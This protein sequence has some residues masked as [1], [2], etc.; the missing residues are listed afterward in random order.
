MPLNSWWKFRFQQNFLIGRYQWPHSAWF[1]LMNKGCLCLVN[2]P[3]IHTNTSMSENCW[4]KTCK[5][6]VTTLFNFYYP[7]KTFHLNSDFFSLLI[8]QFLTD[9][10]SSGGFISTLLL[11][12]FSTNISR[13]K[14]ETL[15]RNVVFS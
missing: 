8:W 6:S 1:I 10:L 12:S 2:L 7:F 13:L 3:K 9:S 5:Q 15:T 11:F 4:M 14:L